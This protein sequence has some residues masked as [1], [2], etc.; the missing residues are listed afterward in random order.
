VNQCEAN[1]HKQ[2][3]IA[4]LDNTRQ[5]TLAVLEGINP[6]LIVHADSGWRVKD[7]IAHL[8]AWE[9]ESLRSLLAYEHGGEYVLTGYASDHDYNARIF[10]RNVDLDYGLLHDLWMAGRDSFKTAIR[11]LPPEKFTG[12]FLFPWGARASIVM[13]VRDMTVH[14]KEH[15]AEI[16][17]ALDSQS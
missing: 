10:Q 7:L 1:Q 14:E 15:A 13:L 4:R 17:R 9:G 6:D 16:R 5:L 3:L 12:R 11:Q 8:T 2:K